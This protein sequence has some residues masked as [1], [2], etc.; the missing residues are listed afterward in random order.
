VSGGQKIPPLCHNRMAATLQTYIPFVTAKLMTRSAYSVRNSQKLI[1]DQKYYNYKN[2]Y[3]L[4]ALIT[5]MV[6]HIL[7]YLLVTGV[8]SH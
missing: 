2:W 8:V 3:A 7:G 1:N 6:T 4:I 5:L